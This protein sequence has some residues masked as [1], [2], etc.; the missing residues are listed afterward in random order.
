MAHEVV[1]GIIFIILFFIY[2]NYINV[3]YG[4]VGVNC[5]VFLL[6]LRLKPQ[7]KLKINKPYQKWSTPYKRKL[8]GRPNFNTKKLIAKLK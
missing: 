3:G 2:L 4:G 6:K 8:R 1:Y 5:V 7:R